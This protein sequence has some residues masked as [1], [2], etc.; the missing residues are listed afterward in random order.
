MLAQWLGRSG[1]FVL[2]PNSSYSTG[3]PASRRRQA[4]VNGTKSGSS[5][6]RASLW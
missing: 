2:T 6:L 5:G 4:Q 3:R 1:H